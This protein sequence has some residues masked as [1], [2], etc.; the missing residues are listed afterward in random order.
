VDQIMKSFV[1][2]PGEPLLTLSPAGNG[3]LTATQSRFF[4][5][6]ER[7]S[8]GTERWTFPVC[9]SG[10]ACELV[11]E[12]TATVKAGPSPFANADAVGYYRT[13]YTPELLKAVIADAPKLKAPERIDLVGGRLSLMRAGQSSV[14]EY[15]GLVAS[16]RNDASPQ[17]LRQMFQGLGTVRDRIASPEQGKQIDGWTVK[18]FGQVY[19]GLGPMQASESTE[20]LLRRVQLFQLLGEAGEPAVITEAKSNVGH[21][22]ANDGTVNP[23]FSEPSIEIATKYG[24]AA[25]YDKLQGVAE[26][27]SNPALQTEALYSLGMFADPSLVGR[28]L[29]AV[30]AGKVRNQDSWALLAI[31]LSGTE[32]R[33]QTWK[34]IKAHWDQVAAQFT[35]SSGS[36]VVRATGSFCSEAE[37]ADVQQFFATHKVA[38]ADQSVTRAG[39]AIDSCVALRARQ[40]PKLTE[41][42]AQQSQQ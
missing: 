39:Q 17:V 36:G 7:P 18:T 6:G 35:T 41:W 33:D 21:L 15:L 12:T 2:Q 11:S 16:L 10:G 37:K 32:T 25:L 20:Q 29:D 26:H 9:M 31:L 30:A 4:L 42:L 28:T 27:S 8:A 34:Y 3:S 24:D 22:L 14:D 23:Q 38:A 19:A 1:E 40:G 5:N 13:N